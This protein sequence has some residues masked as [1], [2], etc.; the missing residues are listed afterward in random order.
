MPILLTDDEISKLINEKKTL[1]FKFDQFLSRQ[2][3]SNGHRR[4]NYEFKSS[5]GNTFCIIL[6]QNKSDLF[7]FSVMLDYIPEETNQKIKLIRYNGKS[8]EHTNKIEGNTFK[9][10][11]HIHYATERY[12]RSGAYK[13]EHYAEQTDRYSNLREAFKC[14]LKDCSIEMLDRHDEQKELFNANG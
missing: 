12:Q 1:P 14:L 4:L 3:E 6:R 7:D 5:S 9:P 11:F 10:D 13:A 2:K 8:H